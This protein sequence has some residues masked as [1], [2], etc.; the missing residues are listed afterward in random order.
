MLVKG[1]KGRLYD[2]H[3]VSMLTLLV[4]LVNAQKRWWLCTKCKIINNWYFCHLTS[5]RNGQGPNATVAFTF[6]I[7]CGMSR[8]FISCFIRCWNCWVIHEIL[9][10][11]IMTD[12]CLIK[13]TCY[14]NSFIGDVMCLYF[15]MSPTLNPSLQLPTAYWLR[16]LFVESTTQNKSYLI[17]SSNHVL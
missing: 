5:Y 14:N 9:P 3:Q 8:Y 13:L 7:S 12:L 11:Y 17:W 2:N 6:Y 16:F 1:A 15:L 4:T 10:F